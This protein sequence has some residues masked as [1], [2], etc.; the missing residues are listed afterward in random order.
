MNLYNSSGK[1]LEKEYLIATI[2]SSQTISSN[3]T[4]NLDSVFD[5]VGDRLTLE[6]GKVTIGKRV[7]KVRVSC[8]MFV[9]SWAGGSNYLWGK[10][11]GN[12]NVLASFITTSSSNYISASI[13]IT[14]VNVNEGDTISIMADSPSNGKLRSGRANTWLIIEIIE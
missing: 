11:M 10:I 14:I 13:P 12:N 5:S 9:D 4:V 8:G 1:K 3:F 6:N 2:T 7:S